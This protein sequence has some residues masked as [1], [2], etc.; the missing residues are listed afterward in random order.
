MLSAF[1]AAALCAAICGFDLAFA[2]APPAIP[3]SPMTA[4]TQQ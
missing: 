3:Q 2:S 1:V 4:Q